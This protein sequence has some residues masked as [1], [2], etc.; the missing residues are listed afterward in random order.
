V[1]EGSERVAPW[2][3]GRAAGVL[4][5]VTS[6]PGG[7]LGP[8]AHR[9][10]DWLAEA[11][12][13]WWQVLPL[14]PPDRTGSPY[15]VG[16]AFA[17]W[18]GLLAEPDAPVSAAEVEDFAARHA[19]WTWD[20]DPARDGDL[21][22]QVRFEREW[23]A[24][25]AHA[26][27]RG[28]RLLGDM[29]LYVAPSSADVRSRP[30]LFAPG[31]VAGAPPDYFSDDG[32]LW[33]SPLYDWAAMRRDGFRWWIE[34]VRRTLELVD[35][36]RIDHFRGLVSYWAVDAGAA[37]ARDGRWRRAPGR[38]ML[39]AVRGE[40]GGAPLVAEDLGVIT[41][42]VERLRREMGLP[43]MVV[44]QWELEDGPVQRSR[45]WPQQD[46]LSY[47]GTHDNATARE[48]WETAPADR[49]RNLVRSLEAAEIDADPE[50]EPHWAFA[51]LAHSAPARLAIVPA[52]DVLG[53]GAEARM[54]TPA[55]VAGNWRWRLEPGQPTDRHAERLREVTEASGRSAAHPRPRRAGRPRGRRAP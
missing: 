30:W 27:S 29:P 24:L 37:T 32:Q 10:V 43:G 19:Y 12:Q 15:E 38:A 35:A 52:Q 23:R 49:R 47:T 8:E 34:R 25:R 45:L 44:L 1:A 41:P 5:H 14:G 7:R 50:A 46:R 22:G 6:L 20:W 18:T 31:E 33:G 40:L 11:G 17:G 4:L 3:A 42:A 53:L 55:T 48:W 28:V 26:H 36:V 9:F 39:E 16:S 21:A 51:R 2:M 13:S 54:N